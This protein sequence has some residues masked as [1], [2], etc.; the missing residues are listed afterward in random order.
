MSFAKQ[1]NDLEGYFHVDVDDI[2]YNFIV[3]SCGK[4]L[5]KW[6]IRIKDG[7]IGSLYV[8]FLLDHAAKHMIK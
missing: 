2:R 5:A 8:L 3:V 6:R 7:K 4:C 1:I